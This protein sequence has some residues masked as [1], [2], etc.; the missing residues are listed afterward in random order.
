[1]TTLNLHTICTLP[2]LN[3]VWTGNSMF[4]SQAVDYI[5]GKLEDTDVG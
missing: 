2:Q 5:T 1:M 3:K 4:N